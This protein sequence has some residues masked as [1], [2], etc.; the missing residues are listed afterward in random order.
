MFDFFDDWEIIAPNVESEDEL[1]EYLEDM[2]S[3]YLDL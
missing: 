2:F 1:E 3:H